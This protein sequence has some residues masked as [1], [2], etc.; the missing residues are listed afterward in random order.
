MADMAHISGL[1]AANVVPGPFEHCDIV[2]STTHKTLRGARSGLIFC[3][4]GNKQT[5]KGPVPYDLEKP[6]KEALFPGLQGGPHNHAIAGVCVALGQ[7]QKEEFIEYQKQV[8]YRSLYKIINTTLGIEKCSSIE[9][10]VDGA[11]LQ[12]GHWWDR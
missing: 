4:V 12:C 10:A 3:R 8:L 6:I 5:P 1:V 9:Y 2:T 11:W 7:A